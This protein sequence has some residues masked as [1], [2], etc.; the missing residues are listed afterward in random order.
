MNVKRNCNNY[1]SL[2]AYAP[3]VSYCQESR[4]RT[5]DS[6]TSASG[7]YQ[8]KEYPALRHILNGSFM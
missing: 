6:S 4:E 7:K 5:G 1:K 2:G 8:R 3:G